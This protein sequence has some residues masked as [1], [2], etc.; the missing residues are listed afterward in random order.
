MFLLWGQDLNSFLLLLK[1]LKAVAFA[2]IQLTAVGYE[3]DGLMK[4]TPVIRCAAVA[5]G[6]DALRR[7][8]VVIIKSGLKKLPR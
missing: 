5:Q 8:L 1:V 4:I 2:R 3:A 7:D 6:F